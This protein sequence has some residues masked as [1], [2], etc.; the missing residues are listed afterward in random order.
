MHGLGHGIIPDVMEIVHS[1]F[2]RYG[3]LASFINFANEILSDVASFRLDYC[4]LK[5]LPK[6]AWVGENSMSYM[7]IMSYLYGMFLLNNPLGRTEEAKITVDFLKCFIN[8]FQVYVSLLMT[9]NPVDPAMHENLMRLFMP[10]AHYLHKCH[11]KLNMKKNGNSGPRKGSNSDQKNPRFVDTCSVDSLRKI[12][13]KMGYKNLTGDLTK[14][15][16]IKRLLAP[17]LKKCCK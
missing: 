14:D 2:K 17:G 6:A 7:R 12:G 16:L 8:S 9:K 5:I 10:A 3:K 15:V 4:K 1:V 11:G 13:E